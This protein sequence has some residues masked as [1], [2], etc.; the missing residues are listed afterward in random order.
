MKNNVNGPQA[1]LNKLTVW[2]EQTHQAGLAGFS[3]PGSS[4]E[5]LL[6]ML[7]GID[8]VRVMYGVPCRHDNPSLEDHVRR[9][10]DAFLKLHQS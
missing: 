10:V 4:A 2:M 1:T 5:L 8:L 9:I 3:R 7:M 6:G